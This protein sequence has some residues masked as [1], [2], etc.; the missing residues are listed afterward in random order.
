MPDVC[1]SSD[2]IYERM[3][4]G[5]IISA[6]QKGDRDALDFIIGRYDGL[7]R[8][9]AKAYY[10]IGADNQDIIQEGMIGLYKAIRDFRAGKQTSFKVFAELCVTRQ[11]ITAIKA[12]T[13][14]KHVPL[15]SYISFNKPLFDEESDRTVID[16]LCSDRTQLDPE[17]LFIGKE[18]FAL[19]EGAI[20]EALSELEQKVLSQYIQGRSYYEISV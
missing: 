16:T 18:N 4:E 12:A 11:I 1:K 6:A 2:R 8:A 7:V 9:K 10:I 19:I 13:R 14:Q 20:S 17:T 5:E 15:N 3:D